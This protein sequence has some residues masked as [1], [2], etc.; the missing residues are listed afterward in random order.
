VAARWLDSVALRVRRSNLG[1]YRCAIGHALPV[2]GDRPLVE[3]TPADI[4]AVLARLVGQG[5]APNTAAL[6]RRVLMGCLS[7]AERDG[8]IPRNAARIARPPKVEPKDRHRLTPA[9]ARR[10]LELAPAIQPSSGPR[11]GPDEG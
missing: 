9:E 3:L 5:M 11:S 6:V 7:D 2:L 1:V 4:E 8:R 10:L